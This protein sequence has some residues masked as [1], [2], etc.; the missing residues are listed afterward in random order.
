MKRPIRYFFEGLLVLVPIVAS[1]YIVFTILS[2]VDGLL[3]IPIPG[4][5]LII[6]ISFITFV[7]LLASNFLTRW[8]FRILEKIFS[9]L[10]FIKIFYTSI[11]DLIGAF[12]GDKKSFDKPVLITMDNSTG[13]KALGFVTKDSLDFLNIKDHVAVYLPQSYN[14][15]GNLFVY[16]AANVEPITADSTDV[17]T[18]LVSGGVSCPEETK[19][20]E[21]QKEL[22]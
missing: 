6:T 12:V 8:M 3:H 4:I 13:L 9:K 11:K 16:P 21:A 19:K 18:F 14:F 17:M 1:I 15:A 20:K 5:G 2:R 7:G 10:P 22:D